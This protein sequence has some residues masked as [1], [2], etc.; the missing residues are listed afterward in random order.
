MAATGKDILS[1]LQTL[2]PVLK[3][4]FRINSLEF[5][6][7]YRRGEQTEENGFQGGCACMRGTVLYLKDQHCLT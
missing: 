4:R 3:Q 2:K 6:G 1:K 7:S 5:F